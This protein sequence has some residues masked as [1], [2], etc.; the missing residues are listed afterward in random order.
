MK[1]HFDI[2]EIKDRLKIWDVMR[3]FGHDVP[4]VCRAVRSPMR[5]E[6]HPSFSIFADGMLAKDHATG[7]SYDVILLF[8]ALQGCNRHEA[9][10]GCG[11]LAGMAA[12]EVPSDMAIPTPPKSRVRQENNGVK[13]KF[14]EQLGENA[15]QHR[16]DMIATALQHLRNGR[17]PLVEFATSKG[18]TLDFMQ[19][20]V[21]AGL[22][23]VFE[24][25]SLRRPA[26]AWL[27]HND[28]FGFGCKLRLDPKASRLTFWWQG[29][30]QHH[31]FGEQL[32]PR[33][34]IGSNDKPKILLTEGES[35]CLAV[36]QMGHMAAGVT[37]SQVMPDPRVTH[38]LLS[39]KRIGVWYDQDKAGREGAAKI[40]QHLLTHTTGSIVRS[41]LGAKVPESLD[42]SDC[43][44][45]WQS[46]F[47]QYVNEELD[48][49]DK[50]N[51]HT[52]PSNPS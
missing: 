48:K 51:K 44:K 45:K 4:E 8:E 24:H 1:N 21:E 37:G 2:D 35:D 50:D 5:E 18:L 41:D 26:I 39:G 49:L 32:I 27:F 52:T 13:S 28:H 46:K 29:K 19:S 25:R 30:S 3:H 6:R 16:E 10:V 47:T 22:I 14:I 11:Q 42:I 34:E 36:A 33:A 38:L 7:D 17:G 20:M 43:N 23:G 15:E 12:D 9:I 40:Q 31:L